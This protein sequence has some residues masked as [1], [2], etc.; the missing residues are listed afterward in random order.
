MKPYTSLLDPSHLSKARAELVLDCLVPALLNHLADSGLDVMVGHDLS[1]VVRFHERNPE[2][3]VFELFDPVCQPSHSPSDT[4][5]LNL[6]RGDEQV[7]IL[8][9][10][11][12]HAYPDLYT[13]MRTLELFH[14]TRDSIPE[15]KI[16]LVPEPVGREVR[17]NFV[18]WGGINYIVPRERHRGIAK[19][20]VRLSRVLT[21]TL[22]AW[23]WSWLVALMTEANMLKIG[24]RS[25][26]FRQ[27]T[28]GV[29]RVMPGQNMADREYW[30]G[31]KER[32]W[33]EEEFFRP[34]TADLDM[35][36]NAPT[37]AAIAA[38]RRDAGWMQ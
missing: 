2:F 9:T 28:N 23:R 34:E 6:F 19:A 11:R 35:A 16:V 7:G 10:R 1:T 38:A 15:G 3:P 33:A 32:R 26:G 25:N 4:L 29:F 5:I 24:T 17:D 12:K 31:L 21:M 27:F 22:P 13:A 8:G 37:P 30:L 36:L 14:E 20:L 18:C